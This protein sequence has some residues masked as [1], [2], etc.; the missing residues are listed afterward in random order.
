MDF[1]LV[2]IITVNFNHPEVTVELLKSLQKITYPNIEIIVVDNASQDSPASIT[3]AFPD[4][5]FI[6]NKE[7]LGFAGGNNIGVNSAKGKYIL[8][9]NNDTEV[10]SDFLEPLVSK[11]ENNAF[12]G[13]VSPKI[14]FYF[15]PNAIQ[16]CGQAPMNPYTMRS[17]GYGYGALD[18]GQFDTDSVT[19]FLHGAAMLIP[20][21]VIKEVGMMTECYFLYYEELDWCTR[22]KKA[23]YKLWYV[24][25]STILHKESIST[26]KLTP[27]K[28]YFM[29]RSRILYLRRN[30]FGIPFLISILFQ[31]FIAIPKNIFVFALKNDKGHLKA[32][33]KAI[34]WHLSHLFSKEIHSNPTLA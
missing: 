18:N 13:G 24:H 20:L 33:I 2:S 19:N 27:F 28:T 29:N 5:I 11:C 34:Y 31:V 26:G 9:I 32:Y 17:F 10:L 3:L 23:G 21:S 6:Q 7:N 8:F 15:Q 14:K 30:L 25:N 12:I 22:I 1:P 4:I 16:Y